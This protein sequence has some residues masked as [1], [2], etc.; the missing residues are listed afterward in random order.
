MRMGQAGGGPRFRHRAAKVA[1]KKALINQSSKT[2][3]HVQKS[4]GL[5]QNKSP[6]TNQSRNSLQTGSGYSVT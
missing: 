3:L 6:A 4:G 1:Q 5:K 2:G